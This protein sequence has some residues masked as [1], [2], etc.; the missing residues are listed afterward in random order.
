[1]NVVYEYSRDTSE[2]EQPPNIEYSIITPIHNQSEIIIENI[3]SV[4]DSTVGDFELI[5]IFDGCN[6]HSDTIVVEF[7]HSNET[8]IPPQLKS[9]KCFYEP[10]S[11]F[12]TSAD[13]IGFK[14]ARGK[15]WI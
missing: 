13:N 6:D 10:D 1:M 14:N 7:F 4:I 2:K 12:E 9:I 15:Y 11:R 8:K 3:K 5:Y